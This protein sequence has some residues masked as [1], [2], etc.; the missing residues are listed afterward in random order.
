MTNPLAGR[1]LISI[2]D[3]SDFQL[4]LVMDTARRMEGSFTSSRASVRRLAPT[5]TDRILATLFYE[6][7]TRTRFFFEAAMLYL[8]GSVI[9]SPDATSTTKVTAGE[10]LED[11]GQILNGC[12]DIAVIRHGR[13][14]SA[15]ELAKKTT[16]PIIN[17]GDGMNEH[18]TQTLLDLYTLLK[19]FGLG[20][21]DKLAELR[22]VALIGDLKRGRTV[23]SLCQALARFNTRMVFVSPAS[24]SMPSPF[25]DKVREFSPAGFEPTDD[26]AETLKEVDAAYMT[27]TQLERIEDPRMSGPRLSKAR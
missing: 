19:E 7:S 8:G 9:P 27:R 10:S 21:L 2:N 26:L 14:G 3:L 23:H 11:T 20:T 13:E 6:S 25:C 17:G 5:M 24:L 18:P 12:A 22:G 4:A 1:D 16:I 15:A